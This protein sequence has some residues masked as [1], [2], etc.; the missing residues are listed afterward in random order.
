MSDTI[1]QM[2]KRLNALISDASEQLQAERAGQEQI[3][4]DALTGLSQD[5]AVSAAYA[6]GRTDERMRC[7]ALIDDHLHTLNRTGINALALE[8]LRSAVEGL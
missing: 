8:A 3:L 6:E 2:R 1:E 5:S 4:I 7:L